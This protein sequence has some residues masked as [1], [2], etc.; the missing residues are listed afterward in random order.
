MTTLC[1]H[2]PYSGYCCPSGMNGARM[3]WLAASQDRPP[4]LVR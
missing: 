2:W 1:T 3:P 4:S